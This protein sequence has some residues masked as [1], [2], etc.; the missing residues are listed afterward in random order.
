VS[1]QTSTRE[2]IAV[3]ALR[4]LENARIPRNAAA[5]M[6][7]LSFSE[8]SQQAG[9]DILR[10]L[11]DSEWEKLLAI[12]NS[13]AITLVAG[14]LCHNDLSPRVR[15]R[16]DRD[17]ARNAERL[18]RL[19][20]EL[21]AVARQLEAERVEFLLLKGFS[22]GPE[23]TLDPRLRMHTDLDLFVPRDSVQRA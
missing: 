10:R 4:W 5:L 8:A 9:H 7:V 21:T 3:P 16:I 17:I 1:L 11:S 22:L 19:R 13:G 12:A 2:L 20:S 23:Y 14:T 15:P 6:A 18:S